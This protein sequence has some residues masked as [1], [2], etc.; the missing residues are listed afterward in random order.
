MPKF[1]FNTRTVA[2]L[3]V[4]AT[5]WGCP[6][7][8]GT[9]G[10]PSFDDEPDNGG[11]SFLGQPTPKPNTSP[12]PKPSPTPTPNPGASATPTPSPT[13]T[14]T[15]GPTPTPQTRLESL[16]VLNRISQMWLLEAVPTV[17]PPISIPSTYSFRAEVVTRVGTQLPSTS[18]SVVWSS[19]NP[20][21]LSIHPDTGYASTSVAQGL[22]L[23]TIQAATSNPLAANT[24]S[25]ATVVITVGNSGTLDVTIE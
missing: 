18:S 5:L 23:V 1:R 2:L 12:T 19:S 9:G 13:P 7:T 10:T 20:A 8:V 11:G 15:P 14:G 6:A 17:T 3:A 21:I 16:Q 22:F 25:P 24:I 4:C